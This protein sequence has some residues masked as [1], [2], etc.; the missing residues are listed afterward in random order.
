MENNE[1]DPLIGSYIL[2][3]YKILEKIG[4]GSFG[5]VYVASFSNTNDLFAVKLVIIS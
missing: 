2:K 5:K 4:E 3:E 1:E